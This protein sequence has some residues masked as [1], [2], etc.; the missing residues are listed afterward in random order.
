MQNHR[1]GQ[2]SLTST[3]FSQLCA[4]FRLQESR[5]FI[6]ILLLM[7]GMGTA[8]SAHA[9]PAF[10][11]NSGFVVLPAMNLGPCSLLRPEIQRQ[12][13]PVDE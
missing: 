5:I 10:A 9:L 12:R 4:K 11:R 3:L 13:L 6:A 2:S 1:T 7:L 8:P